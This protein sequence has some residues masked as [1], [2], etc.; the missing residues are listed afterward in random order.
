MKFRAKILQGD[1]TATSIEVP[2]QFA[3]AL[4]SKRPKVR[5]TIESFVERLHAG[6]GRADRAAVTTTRHRAYGGA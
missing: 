5:A 2:A 3:D 1:K 6:Q 4:G